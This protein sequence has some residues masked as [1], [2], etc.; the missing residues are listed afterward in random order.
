MAAMP[1][2]NDFDLQASHTQEWP[3]LLFNNRALFSDYYLTERL[4]QGEEWRENVT[5]ILH[6]FRE[7]FINVRQRVD[8]RGGATMR[9]EV[10]EPALR[11]LGFSMVRNPFVPAVGPG[12]CLLAVEG[13]DQPVASVMAYAWGRNLDKR[14]DEQYDDE[15]PD[16]NPGAF[17]V[18]LLAQTDAPDWA[19]VTNGKLW[20]LYTARA[21]SRAT[22]YYEIDLEE[23]LASPE[24]ELAFR[25]FWLFFR[26]R[27]FEP[28][29]RRGGRCFLDGIFE[30]SSLFAQELGGRLKERIFEQ[31]FPSFAEGFIQSIRA[32]DGTRA[33]FGP[34]RLD[35]IFRG[36]LTFLYRLLFLLYAESRE[37]LPVRSVR[38]YYSISLTKLKEEIASKAGT[39]LDEVPAKLERAYSAQTT[40]LYQQLGVLFAAIDRGDPQRNVPLYNGGLFLVTPDTGDRSP[41]AE[42]ARFLAA[43]TIP[44]RFLA[45]GLD[46]LARDID[47]K[48]GDLVFVDYKSLGVRQFGAIYEGLLEFKLQLANK[49]LAV[50]RGKSTEEIMPYDEALRHRRSI[51]KRGRGRNAPE[52][53]IEPGALYL[54]NDKR[55]RKATGSYY[56]PDYIV[57]YLVR[58][59]VGPVLEAKCTALLPDIHLAQE[60]FRKAGQHSPAGGKVAPDRSALLDEIVGP[61]VADLFSLRVCDPAMGSGHFLVEAVDYITDYLVRFMEGFPFLSHFFAGMRRAILA[62]MEQQ[63][64]IIDPACLSDVNLLKRHVLK[65]CVYGVDKNAMAVELAKVSLWLDCFTIG[66]PLSFLDHHLKCGNSLIG[67]RLLEVNK[68]LTGGQRLLFGGSWSAGVMLATDLMRRVGDLEDV[69]A[70]Q[71]RQSRAEFRVAS[72]ALAPYKRILD[73]YTSRWFGNQ[74]SKAQ[75]RSGLLPTLDFLHDEQTRAWLDDPEGAVADLPAERQQIAETAIQAAAQQQ[76]FHWELEFPE[77]FFSRDAIN[78]TAIPGLKA[79]GGFDV[80]VG[81]PPYVRAVRLRDVAPEAWAYFP[82]VF[83]SAAKGEY[84]IYLCFA[85]QGYN[86]LQK[87]GLFGM[88]IPNKW[89]TS[90]VGQ[91]L[92]SMLAEHRV[93]RQI[94]DYG[95]YQVF[96]EVTTY[97]CLLFFGK[98]PVAKVRVDNLIRA[99]ASL[100]PLPDSEGK[101]QAPADL[102][103]L[104]VTGTW[105]FA[106]DATQSILDKLA[107]LD[108]L[109]QI[110]DIFKGTGT[111]ADAVFHMRRV[112]DKYYS[113]S[114][115]AYVNI[116]EDLMK[117]SLTGRDIE[118][119][120]Y[121]KEHYLLFPYEVQGD[122]VALISPEQMKRRFPK[123][124]AYL[125][126]PVN[127]A[128]LEGRDKGQFSQR[129]DWYG[130]GRPQNMHILGLP[131]LVCPDVA[132]KAEFA[133]DKEGRYII[134][135]AYGVRLKN[136]SNL[137]LEALVAL[138]NSSMMTFFLQQTGTILRGGFFRMKTAYLN[139]FPIPR[140]FSAIT[141]ENAEYIAEMREN[142]IN[143]EKYDYEIVDVVEECLSEEPEDA[144]EVYSILDQLGDMRTYL[145]LTYATEQAVKL[146]RE[147]YDLKGQFWHWIDQNVPVRPDKHGK[148]GIDSLNGK[149]RLQRAIENLSLAD[150]EDVLFKNKGR[151]EINFADVQRRLQRKFA[152]IAEQL[153]PIQAKITRV[154][155][156]IDQVVY[157][158]YGLSP[159]EIAVVEEGRLMRADRTVTSPPK[160]TTLAATTDADLI[161]AVLQELDYGVA[162]LADL[163]GRVVNRNPLRSTPR[164]L[165]EDLVREL[166]AVDWAEEAQGNLRLSGIVPPALLAPA[167]TVQQL[168]LEL[169]LAHE[170][171]NNSIVS[172]LLNR[173]RTLAPHRQGAIV[174]PEP[175]LS[176]PSSRDQL[177]E[178]GRSQAI[179]WASKLRSEYPVTAN[180]LDDQSLGN[181]LTTQFAELAALQTAAQRSSRAAE[182]IRNAFAGELF[183]DIAAPRELIYTLIPR[184]ALAGLLMWARRLFGVSGIAIFPVGKFRNPDD[185]VDSAG[186]WQPGENYRRVAGSSGE[187]ALQSYALH[188]P[189]DEV[190]LERFVQVLASEYQLLRR[191]ER[192]PYVSLLTCRDRVCYRLR[193]GNPVFERLLGEAVVRSAAR[194]ISTSIAIES[195]QNWAERGSNARE[196]PVIVDGPRYLLALEER[197]RGA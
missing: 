106:S 127:R 185:P 59:T 68:A 19:I 15:T 94:V 160:R 39:I 109:E 155:H 11:V 21:Q 67:A 145:T 187:I 72:E 31:I 110:V 20:R 116:E 36:T 165:V 103:E 177:A 107:R 69:T 195:D 163:A 104:S 48:R 168:H 125:C 190:S 43:H 24:P 73:V 170:L 51:L 49:H 194:Q 157:R 61:V 120:Y 45:L 5:P 91:A 22:N 86:L 98:K 172:A 174:L 166:R 167:S 134:D 162:S 12:D 141:K 123:A 78:E 17:V 55:E 38:D 126:D 47:P 65:R 41:E 13:S 10:I 159:A 146:N 53:L 82:Q 144:V 182:L 197:R 8:R 44:D 100:Q 37:L 23:A 112:G 90:Q 152:D 46:R 179:E 50:V 62:E 57:Q 4:R 193:I 128:M 105:S 176:L 71:L 156:L 178:Y 88:I 183:R 130:Y 131:K 191:K 83:Q 147:R 121:E 192:Q 75:L 122:Q 150:I 154:D 132:A 54:E 16:R 33:D 153:R 164:S 108:R 92:R 40:T 56:T 63:G 139:P 133:H 29:Q 93:V 111:S 6:S 28:D 64:V 117:P 7:L 80:V 99:D 136:D 173:L 142:P 149:N 140:V 101:W 119:Y 181:S 34:E 95:A 129:E 135:T 66:A 26:A 9:A 70:E 151:L 1:L 180:Y 137:S 113:R 158:M 196:L 161:R 14:D 18:S 102:S 30:G 35:T 27:A 77:V 138:L 32:Q 143:E 114:L 79:D 189:L 148:T 97:T 3:E 74:P 169:A 85:E 42:S 96:P 2:Q 58:Q 25:Y 175:V 52:W 118:P 76:F 115:G 60:R 84:D 188:F 87:H 81:N 89:M 171:H 184:L 124:W 186:V